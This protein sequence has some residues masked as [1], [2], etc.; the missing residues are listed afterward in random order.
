M[1]SYY[2]L[3][4]SLPELRTDGEMPLTYREFLSLCQSNVSDSVYELLENLTLSSTKG[5]LV[6][7][8]AKFYGMLRKELSYQRSVNLGKSYSSAYDKDGFISQ[9]VSS[10]LSAKNPLEAEKILLDYEFENLDS[11]V[12]LHMFDEYVLFGYA[13][14][15][16]LLERLS[17]FE[18]EKGKAEF[19]TL[20]EGI[21]RRVYSM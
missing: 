2:Y 3:I 10:A 8:W 19:Q 15:L 7:D 12:G 16:K 18:Q 11:L 17:C 21:Q 14:K 4:A 1:A 9:V 6:E 20:F 13:I 5:P